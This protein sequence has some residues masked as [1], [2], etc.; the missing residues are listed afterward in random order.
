[1]NEDA[2]RAILHRARNEGRAQLTA[3]EAG[4]VCRAYGLPLPA[5]RVARD[6]GAAVTA[7]RAVGYPVALKVLSAGI[8]HKS[9]VG[10]ITLDVRDD[11][12]VREAFDR[13]VANA[14]RAEPGASI[15]GV[16]VQAMARPG[17]EVIVGTVTDPTFGKMVM[18]G[19]G[20]IFVETLRDVTFGLAP[21]SRERALA[22]FQELRGY[23]ILAGVR[24]E[25]PHLVVV[26]RRERVRLKVGQDRVAHVRSHAAGDDD[27]LQPVAADDV[28]VAGERIGAK[29]G[30]RV[31]PDAEVVLTNHGGPAEFL[32][33]QG[34]PIGAPVFQ[35]GPFVMNTP[36]ELRQAVDD[37]RRTGFGGWPWAGPAP[38]HARAEGRFALH[39]DGKVEHRE[40]QQAR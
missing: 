28:V 30:A 31:R 14:R 37:Y 26:E 1:M 16:L 40:M 17:R 13:V 23:P 11:A 21:V 33:L 2:V 7:A 4:D 19:L 15:E 6:A 9:D 38:V 8:S 39:A 27:A 35:M 10:G 5:E 29:T 12:G 22:M 36:E 24:G 32:M 20:G 18:V 3:A 34:M 25:A